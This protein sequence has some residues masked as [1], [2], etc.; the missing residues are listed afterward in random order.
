MKTA[1]LN[2]IHGNRPALEATLAEVDALGCDLIVVGGDAALGPLPRETLDLLMA[3]GEQVKWVRGNCDRDMITT[4]EYKIALS[5]RVTL[6]VR[7]AA[8]RLTLAQR[9]LLAALPL[10]LE[11]EIDGL[12]PVLF[13]HGTPRSE[14]EIVTQLTPERRLQGILAGIGPRVVVGG[15]THVQYD[16]KVLGRRLINAGSVGMPFEG[17]TGAFWALLGPDVELRR[18]DYDVEQAAREIL[19]SGYPDAEEF[20]RKDLLSPA[21]PV[22]MSELFERMA[23]ERARQESAR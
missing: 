6:R 13:C 7:W 9:Q 1:V 14:D 19:A 20:A 10:T 16:R 22:E 3:R 4:P 12:G 21:S 18:T 8:E 5:E 15:H 17:R 11:L 23:E 2:D